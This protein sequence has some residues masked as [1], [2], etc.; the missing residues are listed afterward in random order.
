MNLINEIKRK[1][2]ALYDSPVKY[3]KKDAINGIAKGKVISSNI[4]SS[5]DITGTVID[6][7]FWNGIVWVLLDVN[8]S[9]C[10]NYVKKAT[11]KEKTAYNLFTKEVYKPVLKRLTVLL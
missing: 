9:V 1:H 8:C 5:K 3:I 6:F 4:G 2:K 11:D 10:I 7:Y